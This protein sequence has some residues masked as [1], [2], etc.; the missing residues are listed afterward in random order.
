MSCVKLLMNGEGGTAA[1]A[2]KEG[3]LALNSNG[4]TSDAPCG[5]SSNVLHTLRA[6]AF[7]E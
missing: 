7:G 1:A 3:N 4:G 2:G 5:V 6:T